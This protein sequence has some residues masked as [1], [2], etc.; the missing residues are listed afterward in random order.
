MATLKTTLPAHLVAEKHNEEY[1]TVWNRF[2]VFADSQRKA[3]TMWFFV[4]LVVQGIFFLP[5]PVALVYFYN[6]PLIVVIIS[7]ICFFAS[8]IS[9]MGG[10]GIRSTLILSAA[11]ILIQVV[12]ALIVMIW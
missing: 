2:L 4:A 7:M 9:Y 10:A 3:Q 6:A 11:S 8:I 5:L 1:V 12:M